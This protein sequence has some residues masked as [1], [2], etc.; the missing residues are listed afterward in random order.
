[1]SA[2]LEIQYEKARTDYLAAK[3]NHKAVKPKW[4]KLR[5]LRTKL[6]KAKR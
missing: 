5:E 2:R 6:L 3:G 1:M 4:R